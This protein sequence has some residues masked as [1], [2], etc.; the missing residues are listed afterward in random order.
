MQLRLAVWSLTV[1][2]EF[3]NTEAYAQQMD[4]ADPLA[5]FRKEFYLPA[6]TIYL[7]GNSLGLLCRPAEDALLQ[8]VLEWK[9]LAIR[10]WLESHPPWFL[11]AERL[12][13][14]LAPL[15]GAE[16]DE[17]IAANSTTVNLHQMLATFYNPRAKRQKILADDLCFPSDRYALESFVRLVG[18]VPDQIIRYVPS[19][20]GLTL[21]EQRLID[22]MADDVQLVILPAVL[23]VSGQLL[24]IPRLTA[25][26]R[27]R[28]VVIGFDCSHSVGAVPHQ[29][30]TDGVDFAFFCTYKYLNGGPG[31]IGALYLNR[32][33][34][35]RAAGLA[36]WFG[37][38]KDRQFEMGAQFIQASSAG[39]L[40]IGTPPVLA[41]AALRGSL[42][43][44]QEAGMDAIRSKS[45]Q[46][47][48]YL[49]YLVRQRLDGLGFRC[50]G[51]ADDERR[52]G[53]VA[54]Q[55]A[56]ALQ[57]SSKLRER[58][59]IPDF[60]Q[61]NILRFAP[62]PLYTTFLECRRA[63]EQ[64]ELIVRDDDLGSESSDHGPWIT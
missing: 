6:E 34:F 61:P 5:R 36:G 40:Q 11:L 60:R 63:V 64:L 52:G 26:A 16:A 32:R 48:R 49:R 31:A 28:G 15:I 50:V 39:G 12:G 27:D 24:D 1:M 33:H 14:Q 21:D 44:I 8:T 19:D 43:L 23:Y 56:Q 53:H 35:Q 13:E 58:G 30:A 20:D 55:H 2:S 47:T 9:T 3:E 22:A 25:A 51:P 7:D 37:C 46:L 59:V 42:R 54:V 62:A 18:K 10:G 4:Q 57:I 29:F 17:V 45:L 41:A 38:K